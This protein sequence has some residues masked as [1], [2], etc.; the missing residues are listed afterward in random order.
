MHLAAKAAADCQ[1]GRAAQARNDL[2]T[3]QVAPERYCNVDLT[4]AFEVV[5]DNRS[6]GT[7]FRCEHVGQLVLQSSMH[8][9]AEVVADSV[10]SGM[11]TDAAVAEDCS[12]AVVSQTEI[13]EASV[14]M[15]VAA[16]MRKSHSSGCLENKH[17]DHPWVRLLLEQELQDRRTDCTEPDTELV[18]RWHN[19][20]D[21]TAVSG[22]AV[23][24]A[25]ERRAEDCTSGVAG[26]GQHTTMRTK[27]LAVKQEHCSSILLATA[28]QGRQWAAGCMYVAQGIAAAVEAAAAAAAA[29]GLRILH[30][31]LAGIGCMD[32]I[33]LGNDWTKAA[34]IGR[35]GSK[36]C[37]R[38]SGCGRA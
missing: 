35:P 28:A 14:C 18:L 20:E 9:I 12:A 31:A 16:A 15:Q 37:C 8:T 4:V 22:L 34:G 7:A 30:F 13:A 33:D 38:G 2:P 32:R 17:T 26:I 27:W 36:T 6:R 5:A 25:I 29:A 24:E 10:A 11:H 1:V 21:Y 23:I 3:S 19:S